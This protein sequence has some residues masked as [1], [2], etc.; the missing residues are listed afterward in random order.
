[1]AARGN[2][3]GVMIKLKDDISGGVIPGISANSLRREIARGSRRPKRCKKILLR[4]GA[5]SSDMFT[6]PL[7]GTHPSGTV[8]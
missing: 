6:R 4:A 2:I 3:L 7:M 5:G 8:G 1:M